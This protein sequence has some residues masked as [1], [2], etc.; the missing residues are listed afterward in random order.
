MIDDRLAN[1]KNRR[2]ITS[3][4]FAFITKLLNTFHNAYPIY[5][6]EVA[7]MF[8]FTRPGLNKSRSERLEQYEN[9]YATVVATY[10]LITEHRLLDHT[11]ELFKAKFPAVKITDFKILDFIYWQA[12]KLFMKES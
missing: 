6:S 4:Q 10:Q 2:G 9:Q 1:I 3:L 7:N 11:I 5:D 12:G 8:G